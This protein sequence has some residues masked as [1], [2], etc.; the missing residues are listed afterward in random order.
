MRD[1]T[2]RR[3]AFLAACVLVLLPPAAFAHA[4]IDERIAD[5]TKEIVAEPANANL[6]IKRG[7]LHR[8]HRDWPAAL[9]D[10]ERAARL[11][12]S[13]DRILLSRGRLGFESG[14]YETARA[15]LDRYI[16]KHPGDHEARLVRARLFGK[17]QAW[18]AAV[19]DYDRLIE[20]LPRPAP[21]YYIERAEAEAAQGVSHVPAALAG[22][23]RGIAKLG[24]VLSL[25]QPAIELEL[26]LKNWDSALARLDTMARWLAPERLWRRR[27]E[28]LAQAGRA[29]EASQAF[30]RAL[31]VVSQMPPRRRNAPAMREFERELRAELAAGRRDSSTNQ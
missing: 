29:D 26:R 11:D 17:L 10:F 16:E 1:R 13:L 24:A 25:Q 7:E 21:E 19:G 22:I 9:S 12:P 6:Y 5:V 3:N 2:Q 31:E 30:R 28:V 4:G 14:D 23:D 20:L 18:Q 8:L 27:G 15:D